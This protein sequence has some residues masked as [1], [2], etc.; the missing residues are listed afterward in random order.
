MVE[1]ALLQENLHIQVNVPLTAENIH[2]NDD[3]PVIAFDYLSPDEEVTFSQ[4]SAS[5]P[6]YVPNT[7]ASAHTTRA[8][9]PGGPEKFDDYI[10]SKISLVLGCNHGN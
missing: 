2:K 10:A 9:F 3:E 5:S 6:S 8:E 7:W 1:L 4:V